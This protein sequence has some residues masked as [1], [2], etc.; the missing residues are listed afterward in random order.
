MTEPA[1]PTAQNGALILGACP[2]S[3]EALLRERWPFAVVLQLGPTFWR[4]D[5]SQAEPGAFPG[6][7]D[8]ATL[9]AIS[10]LGPQAVIGFFCDG[11]G[12]FEGV[13]IYEAGREVLRARIAWADAPTPDS[14]TWPI[15]RAAMM[16]GVPPELIT[17]VPRPPRPPLTLAL[18]ALHQQ[19]PV[20]DDVVRRQAIDVLGHTLDEPAEAILL[21][22]LTAEDWVDRSHAVR[23]YAR[24]RRAFGEDERPT[25]DALLDDDDE[26]VREALFE[27]LQVLIGAVEF[28]DA[29][30]HKQ[31]DAAIARGLTD[32][33]ED[34]QAAA[35]EAQELRKSLLG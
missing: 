3:V 24:L 35:A 9:T 29:E 2:E 16:L 27:G 14:I 30:A 34:V 7:N 17:Q 28:S 21:R 6:F 13:R 32:E 19:R 1:A 22:F 26:S 33:D 25:L 31:I 20:E 23:S 4:V 8:A 15:G 18:E 11:E 5:L 10:Q 12:G